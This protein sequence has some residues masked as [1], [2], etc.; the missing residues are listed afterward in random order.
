MNM[1]SNQG[2]LLNHRI[3]LAVIMK[4]SQQK[5]SFDGNIAAGELRMSHIVP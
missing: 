3:A 1:T 5:K 4:E 2:V